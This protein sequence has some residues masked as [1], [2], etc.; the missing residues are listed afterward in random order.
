MGRVLLAV[1]VAVMLGSAGTA[2]AMDTPTID[3]PVEGAALG[4]NYDISGSMPYKALLVVLTDCIRVDTGE[5]LRSVPGIRH[6]TNQ[7]GTFAFR[8]ASPRVSLGDRDVVLEYK[9]RCFEI[10]AAG[11]KGPEAVVN[12]RMAD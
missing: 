3:E 2:L 1:M 7:D 12:C 11:E 5:V 8:C 6:Y 10:N 4:P 9:V